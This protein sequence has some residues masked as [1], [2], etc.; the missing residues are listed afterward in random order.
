MRSK[1]EGGLHWICFLKNLILIVY[2][3]MTGFYGKIFDIYVNKCKCETSSIAP[4]R[5]PLEKDRS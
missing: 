5:A 2:G 1:R 4:L 3:H